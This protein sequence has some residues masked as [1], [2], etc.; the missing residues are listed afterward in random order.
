MAELDY[1]DPEWVAAQLG[2]DKNT[3]YKYLQDGTLPGLQ[4]GRKWLVSE[5]TLA[6]A[7]DEETRTQTALRRMPAMTPV[8]ARVWDLAREEAARYRHTYL[9]QEHLLLGLVGVEEST[10]GEVLR[11]LGAAA[12]EVRRTIGAIVKPGPPQETESSVAQTRELT[13]HARR[14]LTLASESAQLD[15]MA[16]VAP[17]HLL[18][19]LLKAGEGVGFWVLEKLG[20]DLESARAQI[21]QLLE[22]R[23]LDKVK[24]GR[25]E[26]LPDGF[27]FVRL[28]AARPAEGEGPSDLSDALP[29]AARS[30]VYLS[31]GIIRKHALV[32]GMTVKV[33]WRYPRGGERYLSA[34]SVVEVDG[35]ATM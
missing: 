19:G 33:T 5:S 35:A 1:R 32:T 4:I 2:L 8:A 22:D 14:A 10:A 11:N 31:P 23:G 27:G 18:V 13:P 34:T 16:A 9:G 15:G 30:D 21:Q 29:D 25:V 20:V 26:V 6:E 24:A 17:E 3:V 28:G 7:L 12:A